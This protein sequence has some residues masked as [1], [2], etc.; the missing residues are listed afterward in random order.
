MVLNRCHFNHLR[1]P[2]IVLLVPVFACVRM[3]IESCSIVY[4]TGVQA[5]CFMAFNVSTSI[6]YFFS[7]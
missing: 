6:P 5:P 3:G 1:N 7:R 4:Q 2:G